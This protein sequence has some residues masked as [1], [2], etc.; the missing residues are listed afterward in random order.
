MSLCL[1]EDELIAV[2]G[3]RQPKRQLEVLR[4]Q[5]YPAFMRRDNTVS[6]GRAQYENGPQ[7]QESKLHA[8]TLRPLTRRHGKTPKA[9][10]RPAGQRPTETR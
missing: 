2:T 7:G 5:G 8:P 10:G 6:L 1:T 4:K 3:Q 9:P